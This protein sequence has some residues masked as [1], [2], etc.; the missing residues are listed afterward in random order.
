MP[1]AEKR[2][3]NELSM[4][5]KAIKPSELLQ[6]EYTFGSP[7]TTSLN[8]ENCVPQHYLQYHHTLETVESLILQM[9]FDQ[10]YPIFAAEDHT[11]IY[12]QVGIVGV[13]NYLPKSKQTAKIVY[14]RKWRVEPNLP[15][16]EIIQTVLLA[17][18]TAR[19]HELRELFKYKITSEDS[20]Q[21]RLTTPFNNHQDLPLLVKSY[22]SASM[23]QAKTGPDVWSIMQSQLARVQYDGVEFYLHHSQRLSAGNY[24]VEVELLPTGDVTLPELTS[25]QFLS[26]TIE[27]LSV[28][29]LLYELM[30]QLLILSNRYVEENFKFQGVARFSRQFDVEGIAK[31]SVAT[32]QL[33]KS[34]EHSEFEHQ[35]LQSNY[36]TDLTRVPNLRKSKLHKKLMQQFEQLGPLSGALPF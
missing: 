4:T 2:V 16:S 3:L 23:T 27:Y 29:H 9:Q 13:D 33:H 8:G 26:F 19:E 34:M 22:H 11:G 5:T 28:N 25:R 31:L 36:E 17:L 7:P 24:L 20:G 12:I 30:A 32:R 14:G 15:T 1:L 35:W 6:G 21:E 18:K 10:H